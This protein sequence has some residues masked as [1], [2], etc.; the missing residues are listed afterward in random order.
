MPTTKGSVA[1]KKKREKY[2]EVKRSRTLKK[3]AKRIFPKMARELRVANQKRSCAEKERELL[4]DANVATVQ[5]ANRQARLFNMTIIEARRSLRN[6]EPVHHEAIRQKDR[7][8]SELERELRA[9][10]TSHKATKAALGALHKRLAKRDRAR[11]YG[12]HDGW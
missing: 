9:E 5:E 3:V 4:R 2:N 10:K 1:D 6:L 8:I 12:E 11:G 7:R